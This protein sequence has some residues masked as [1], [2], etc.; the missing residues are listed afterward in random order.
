MRL[1]NLVDKSYDTIYT[2]VIFPHRKGYMVF[3]VVKKAMI[4]RDLGVAQ[5]ARHLGYSRPYLSNM[6]NGRYSCTK[7]RRAIADFL[8]ENYDEIWKEPSPSKSK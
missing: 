3:K 6:I 2:S 5:L 4:D 7:A 8:G 1:I